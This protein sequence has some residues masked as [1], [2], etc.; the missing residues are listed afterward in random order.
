MQSNDSLSILQRNLDDNALSI[1]GT[2]LA[3]E[4]HVLVQL[5]KMYIEF[6]KFVYQ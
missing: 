2:F 1:L 6:Y 5:D 4:A 3:L